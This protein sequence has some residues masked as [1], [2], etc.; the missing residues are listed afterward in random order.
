MIKSLLIALTL[1]SNSALADKNNIIA[2][3]NAYFPNVTEQDINPTPFKGLY[4]VIL[5]SPR[6]DVI[7]I[8]EDGRYLA[9]GEVIDLKTRKN[10]TQSRLSSLAKEILATTTDDEKVIYKA[11]DEQYVINVF[12]DVDCPFCRKLHKDVAAL[13]KLGITMKYLAFPRSGVNTKSYYRSVAIWCADDQKQA[14][15]R[16]MIQKGN[17]L[18]ECT[19]PVIDHLI[20]AKKLNVTGTPFI[21]F[22]NG[23]N[24]PGYVKPKALLKEIK[25]SLAKYQ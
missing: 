2:G 9:Q 12:T 23:D 18:N 17:T 4:E 11:D 5:R 21:F 8:S 10:L 15:D 1:L 19:N 22:E 13:N 3:V 24:I 16:G 20:L 14:M 7:Y 6:L 25:R